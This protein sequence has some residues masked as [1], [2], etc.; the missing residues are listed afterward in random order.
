MDDSNQQVNVKI[1]MST[2]FCRNTLDQEYCESINMNFEYE[3]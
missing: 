2:H 3:Y 1:R